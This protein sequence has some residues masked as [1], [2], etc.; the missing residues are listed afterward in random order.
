MEFDAST[1]LDW[2]KYRCIRSCSLKKLFA[3]MKGG[4]RQLE[5]IKVVITNS[6]KKM[7]EALGKAGSSRN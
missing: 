2:S 1:V 3:D 7:A 5:K 4:F 6:H